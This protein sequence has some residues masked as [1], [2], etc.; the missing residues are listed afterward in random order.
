[1]LYTAATKTALKI[2]YEAH[3]E[4][5][6]KSGLPY[7]FHPFHLAEQMET[8][9]EVCAALLHD[10][11]EDTDTT[12]EDLVAAGIPRT[13]VDTCLLLRHSPGV[14]YMD[15]VAALKDDPVARRVKIADLRHNSDLSRLDG[16]PTEKDLQRVEKYRK[17]LALL[18]EVG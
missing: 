7:V 11:M 13:Y 5:V 18:G 14:P 9:H 10:V 3:A 2:C 6:D 15:Y 12:A 16:E 1:M 8:E 4:Q 17:A